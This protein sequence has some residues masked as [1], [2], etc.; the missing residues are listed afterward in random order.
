[1]GIRIYKPT[2]AGRRNASV[3]DFSELT[4]K[5]K[6]PEKSLTEPQ[7]K[8]GGR[9]NQGFITSRHKG[10]GHKR[11]YRVIDWHRNDRDGELALVTHIEYDPNRSARIALIKYEDG[12]K[13][14]I[15][16][17]DGLKAG[18][19]VSSGSEAEPKLGNCLP[20][21]KIPT[22]LTIHN[23][24]MQ[25]GGG[26]K[27]VRSAG[28]GAVLTAREGTWAQLTLPS[29]EVRRIPATCRATIGMVGNPDH[30]NVRLGK[31]GRARWL[32]RRPHVRGV[33]MNPVDH[34]MGG[35]EG[36]TSGGRHPCSPTGKLAKGGKTRRRRKPSNKAIIRRRKSVRYGQLK[37]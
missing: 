17:P 32:G 20:L 6:K 23:I 26:G 4:D 18:M 5:N 35:G 7:R 14:Y 34:P 15:L 29:G 25:P 36:R 30:M 8:T 28:V 10:G 3:S 24:E 33:A 2:S 27:L 31:A 37:V 22:G 9:N 13:R 19:T 1:M 12:Q 11:M 21:A 16:A